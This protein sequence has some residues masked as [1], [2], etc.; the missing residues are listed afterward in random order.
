VDVC[1]VTYRNSADRV[2]GALRPEDKLFVRDNTAENIGFAAGANAAAAQGSDSLIAFVN[3][4]GRPASGCFEALERALDDPELV[5]VEAAVRPPVPGHEPGRDSDLD[6]LF[7][8]CMAVRREAFE[9]VGGF[10]GRLFMYYEDV[11]LSYRLAGHGA[12][13]MCRKA[14][15]EHHPGS[16]P[17]RAQHRLYRNFL[18]VERRNGH[19][20]N[21]ALLTQLVRDAVGAARQGDWARACARISGATDYVVRARRWAAR[22]SLLAKPEPKSAHADA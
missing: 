10:D 16:R 5:A 3:P 18:V 21:A 6:F 22:P 15:F 11:D 7:A 2:A 12:L 13:T 9:A 19:G 8:T 14:V 20:S 4:D 1:V 17:F